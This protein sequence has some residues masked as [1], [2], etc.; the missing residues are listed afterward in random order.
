MHCISVGHF[1]SIARHPEVNTG[2]ILVNTDIF[3]KRMLN[4]NNCFIFTHE[5][6]LIQILFHWWLQFY[7]ILFSSFLSFV[8]AFDFS[9]LFFL[10]IH[11]FSLNIMHWLFLFRDRS[12]LNNM[13][14]CRCVYGGEQSC[15]PNNKVYFIMVH[16]FPEVK[17][18]IFS[19]TTGTKIWRKTLLSYHRFK[20]A[21]N[22]LHKI[23]I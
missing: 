21:N 22:S 13:K 17:I 8:L 15:E 19:G 20:L 4:C 7:F 12:Y 1:Q 10:N 11:F 2:V 9:T 16:F 6:T 14:K 3:Q 23:C 5:Y 18:Q